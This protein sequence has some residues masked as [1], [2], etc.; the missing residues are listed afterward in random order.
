MNILSRAILSTKEV[1]KGDLSMIMFF[2]K[3]LSEMENREHQKEGSM[4]M[5]LEAEI[6]K[7]IAFKEDSNMSDIENEIKEKV[8]HKLF[9]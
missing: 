2:Q 6:C 3:L 9:E 4:Y 5:Q 8:L 7:L 1:G